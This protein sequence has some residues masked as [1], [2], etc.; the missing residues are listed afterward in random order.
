MSSL[1][2]VVFALRTMLPA[3]GGQAPLVVIFN[4]GLLVLAAVQLILVISLGQFN[5][6]Y[7]L[8]T[9]KTV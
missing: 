3:A 4:T 5:D 9:V 6:V 7:A 8:C 2:E 1:L